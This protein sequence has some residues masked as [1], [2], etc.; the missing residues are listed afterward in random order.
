MRLCRPTG[1]RVTALS[2]HCVERGLYEVWAP[3]SEVADAHEADV[4]YELQP[5]SRASSSSTIDS[6]SFLN[7][8]V[9]AVSGVPATTGTDSHFAPIV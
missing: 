6:S 2:A 1:D 7:T 8:G 3:A 4:G 5:V 9:G